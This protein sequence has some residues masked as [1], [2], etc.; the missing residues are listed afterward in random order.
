M[1]RRIG[2]INFKDLI[3][4]HEQFLRLTALFTKAG[5]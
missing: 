4:G 1:R 3:L 5:F 2:I